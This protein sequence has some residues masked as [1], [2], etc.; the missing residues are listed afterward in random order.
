MQYQEESLAL[1]RSIG[2]TWGIAWSLHDL[3]LIALGQGE[4][5]RAE[6]RLSEGLALL[7]QLNHRRGVAWSLNGLGAVALATG[8]TAGA[9]ALLAEGLTLRREQ[10]DKRGIAES[11]EYLG[12]IARVGGEAE[13]GARL[14]GAAA[15]LREAIG[16][17]RWPVER[18]RQEHESA[19]AR[20][21]LGGVGFDAAWEEGR[22]MTL[23]SAVADA[24]ANVA[25]PTPG[26]N[27]D[28]MRHDQRSP[29]TPRE[30][31]VAALIARGYTNRRIAAALVISP[32]TAERHVER[33]LAK[34]DCSSRA[35]VAAWT[36]RHGPAGG[37]A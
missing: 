37:Q 6:A 7:R 11:L 26:L 12:A 32:H 14:L 8:D 4:Y 34:L 13:R 23:E 28:D 21:A 27:V 10:G 19:A 15:A 17:P 33:I 36:T 9:R 29:L 31:E 30:R 20:R 3:G 35:E 18:G 24:L 5:R 25:V 16:A 2:D 22:Q 1:R